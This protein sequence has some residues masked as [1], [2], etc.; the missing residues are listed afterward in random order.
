M[1]RQQYRGNC[2]FC[3]A[4]YSK[5]EMS[6][7]LETCQQRANIEAQRE[8]AG[9]AQKISTWH[10]H[11]IGLYAPMYWLHLSVTSETT[12]ATLDCFLRAI[13]LECC[14]HLSAFE[15]GGLRYMVDE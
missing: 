9:M 3:H 10:L 4:E 5:S 8:H 1:S 14:G 2:A 6:R 13:W 15:I 12:L 11:I 7:H